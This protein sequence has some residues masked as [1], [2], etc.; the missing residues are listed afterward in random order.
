M[1]I[2][3]RTASSLISMSLLLAACG[4]SNTAK[5][6]PRNVARTV[7]RV[8][9]P[10]A[11]VN[12]YDNSV[13]FS[14]ALDRFVSISERAPVQG[15]L[16]GYAAA[17]TPSAPT[18][19]LAA[20]R[21]PVTNYKINSITSDGN[22]GLY[23]AGQFEIIGNTER[24]YLAHVLADGTV[25]QA[26]DAELG[27]ATLKP[28][29]GS[30][31]YSPP[32]VL[33]VHPVNDGKVLALVI[34]AI[35]SVGGELLDTYRIQDG[36]SVLTFV[37]AETGARIPATLPDL[38]A[39][40]RYPL[41]DSKRSVDLNVKESE[42]QSVLVVDDTLIVP[43]N[44]LVRLSLNFGETITITRDYQ[45]WDNSRT[46]LG[47]QDWRTFRYVEASVVGSSL[48]LI[49]NLNADGR[50]VAS[51]SLT[52]G[53]LEEWDNRV[54]DAS[55]SIV[56]AV[57]TDN[58]VF[59]LYDNALGASTSPIQGI[60]FALP[61][62]T[63][64]AS[65]FSPQLLLPVAEKPYVSLRRFGSGLA[66]LAQNTV[67]STYS[68]DGTP[69]NLVPRVSGSVTDIN[70]TDD[71]QTAFLLTPSGDVV[72]NPTVLS[73]VMLV[74]R[75]G[76]ST[77]VKLS[78]PRGR[79]WR[80]FG[81][82]GKFVYLVDTPDSEMWGKC[83]P[84]VVE[85]SI[86]PELIA[87][88]RIIRVDMRN[89]QVDPSWQHTPVSFIFLTESVVTDSWLTYP[90]YDDAAGVIR[91]SLNDQRN[92]MMYTEPHTIGDLTCDPYF[93]GTG[94]YVVGDT[95][96]SNN[97]Q[98]SF[99]DDFAV[100]IKVG[101]TSAFDLSEARVV[102]FFPQRGT[103]YQVNDRIVVGACKVPE[104]NYDCY[105]GMSLVD[106][107]T[108]NVIK[109][110][111]ATADPEDLFISLAFNAGESL[112]VK[113]W[114]NKW[115]SFQRANGEYVG[116][117]EARN[118]VAAAYSAADSTL[119]EYS[120][121]WFKGRTTDN[122]ELNG[123]V[124]LDREGKPIVVPK[125]LP[126]V[127]SSSDDETPVDPVPTPTELP[128]PI[129]QAP[130]SVESAGQARRAVALGQVGI[131]KIQSGSR[132]ATVTFASPAPGTQH[133]VS[134]LGTTRTCSTTGNSC[135]VKGL[136]PHL[137]Y[138]FIVYPGDISVAPSPVSQKIKPFVAVKRGKTVRATS[139]VKPASKG[140]VTWK[141][142]G[143]CRFNKQKTTLTA[144]KKRARC[145]ITVTSRAKGK[146][147]ISRT[148]TVS[149]M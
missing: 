137:A 79:L 126:P 101:G 117:A 58:E 24:S 53:T 139:I 65:N 64:T 140:T 67:H 108:G 147:A 42:T 115:T 62:R 69:T 90:I 74:D 149:V 98:C 124:G 3:R 23:V 96:W 107:R 142:K 119:L 35:G 109:D 59:V 51:I 50:Q 99:A 127:P 41:P 57:V 26:F 141:V 120:T 87:S 85:C 131:T 15:L 116:E 82:S 39:V 30:G 37:D 33:S 56:D 93:L 5:D 10:V 83:V 60:A 105:Q 47:I 97:M 70:Q 100:G 16:T 130:A 134:A 31:R 25:N 29:M 21:L 11:D 2:S 76:L 80:P 7:D 136:S 128:V 36:L 133:V 63:S 49:G 122:L 48:V 4:G 28:T 143:S 9:Y 72:F 73:T 113:S 132:S 22:G 68:T 71:G 146:K 138:S 118:G 89:G 94:S 144:P 52:T 27:R 145:T 135:T 1:S 61:R 6:E 19:T 121:Y 75:Q 129:A 123:W 95:V 8:G 45:L 104:F 81:S 54:G 92:T 148:A 91:V 55:T 13:R 111:P 114:S 77:E 125:S 20:E 84:D 18:D 17:V 46:A 14:S 43:G 12:I 86:T 34:R 40:E 112:V 103:F 66:V 44:T 110:N 102:A 78:V 88:Q 106:G 38:G 32:E